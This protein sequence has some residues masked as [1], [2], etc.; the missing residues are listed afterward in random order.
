MARQN[1]EYKYIIYIK[2]YI[3]LYVTYNNNKIGTCVLK[4]KGCQEKSSSGKSTSKNNL[5]R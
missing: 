5:L 1:I 4:W 3:K 2:L